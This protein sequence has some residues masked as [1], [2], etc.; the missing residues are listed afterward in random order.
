ME[1]VKAATGWPFS[2][3]KPPSYL[4]ITITSSMDFSLG[5]LRTSPSM[6]ETLKPFLSK[7]EIESKFIVKP[8]TY[9][10]SF[11]FI[12]VPESSL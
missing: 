2:L 11:I 9:S 8:G 4:P 5:H 10:T 6:K 12:G 7:A 3:Y 1:W